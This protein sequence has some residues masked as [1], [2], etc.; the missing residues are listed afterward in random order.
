MQTFTRD[1]VRRFILD[2]RKESDNKFFD[3]LQVPDVVGEW[4]PQVDT[5]YRVPRFT[6]ARKHSKDT[7]VAG[8]PVRFVIWE[9]R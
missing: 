1:N 3:S 5:V 8:V 9:R 6:E 4:G 2:G 7:V